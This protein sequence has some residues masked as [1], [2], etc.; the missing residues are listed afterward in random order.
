M[1]VSTRLLKVANKD[2]AHIGMMLELMMMNTKD[3]AHIGN[4]NKK[5][6][7]RPIVIV[8]ITDHGWTG[9]L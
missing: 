3:D 2:D 8:S 7:I 5:N 6:N 9:D 4:S 1:F